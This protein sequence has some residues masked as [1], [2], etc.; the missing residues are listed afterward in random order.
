MQHSVKCMGVMLRMVLVA[1]LL[2]DPHHMY[3]MS[4]CGICLQHRN[5]KG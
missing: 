1:N 4:A 3:S 5:D 2:E